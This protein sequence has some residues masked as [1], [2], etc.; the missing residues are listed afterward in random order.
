MPAWSKHACSLP[1]V[2]VSDW[3][4]AVI[5]GAAV[6]ALALSVFALIYA[7]RT[8]L[9]AERAN[10]IALPGVGTADVRWVLEPLD[11]SGAFMLRNVG[12]TTAHDVLVPEDQLGESRVNMPPDEVN[13]RP[14]EAQFV[15]VF[16]SINSGKPITALP[17]QWRGHSEPVFVPMPIPRRSS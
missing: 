12:T 8:A 2:G 13:L 9:A 10:D 1:A 11:G 14:G 17:V 5:G 15:S 7:R 6:L 16:A 4:Q 3:I